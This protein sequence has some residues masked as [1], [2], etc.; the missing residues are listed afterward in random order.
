MNI[1]TLTLN[2]AVDIH[3]RSAECGAASEVISRNSAGKGV[4]LSRAL[5]NNGIDNLC[6][7][8]VGREGCSEFLAP[9]EALG[10]RVEYSLG[11]GRVRENINVQCGEYETVRQGRAEPIARSL[12][13]EIEERLAPKI[14]EETVLALSGSIPEGTDIDAVVGMLLRMRE[15]GARLVLDCR[16]LSTEQT[17]FLKP[18]LIKPNEV[19]AAELTGIDITDTESAVRAAVALRDMG[20]ENVL[21]TLGPSGSVLASGEGIFG[22]TVPRIDAVSSVGAGDSSI[23]G[24]I[25]A[26]VGA[27][28]RTA[29][30]LAMAYGAAACLEEGSLPPSPKNVAWLKDSILIEKICTKM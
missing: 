13:C 2:P 4:N 25:A 5:H 23:A 1:I 6:Y 15:G 14:N 30:A 26:G 12:I 17:V 7:L 16:S 28:S 29:L 24:F 19:E 27:G 10:M 22:A 9:L 8:V 20:C 11:E 21:L 3:M 18:Y